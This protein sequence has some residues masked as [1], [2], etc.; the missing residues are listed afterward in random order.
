MAPSAKNGSMYRNWFALQF[1]DPKSMTEAGLVTDLDKV[2]TLLLCAFY[3]IDG[4]WTVGLSVTSHPGI[5]PS[6]L[7]VYHGEKQVPCEFVQH[8][9]GF[10]VAYIPY[11]LSETTATFSVYYFGKLLQTSSCT[12]DTFCI[13]QYF[14]K[15]NPWLSSSLTP[16]QVSTFA[17]RFAQFRDVDNMIARLHGILARNKASIEAIRARYDMQ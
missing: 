2:H 4:A 14:C 1:Q 6:D 15:N 9:N 11:T 13:E 16:E 10:S 17:Q 3:Y 12:L 8:P 5:R 7:T